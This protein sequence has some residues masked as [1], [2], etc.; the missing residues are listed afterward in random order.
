MTIDIQFRREQAWLLWLPL[1]LVIC[2][3]PGMIVSLDPRANYALAAARGI[4]LIITLL[5]MHGIGFRAFGNRGTRYAKEF[6]SQYRGAILAIFIPSLLASFP[7][8]SLGALVVS[9][10]VFYVIGCATLGATAFGIEFEHRTIGALLAQ[11]VSRWVLLGEKLLPLAT[12]LALSYL[13][14]VLSALIHVLP[15]SVGNVT[16]FSHVDFG[17]NILLLTIPPVFAFCTGPALT[18]LTRRTLAAAVFTIALPPIIVIGLFLSCS[19]LYKF[20]HSVEHGQSFSDVILPDRIPGLFPLF[21][22]LL[23]L[24]L[25]AGLI[26]AVVMFYRL[27]WKESVAQAPS[28]GVHPLAIPLDKLF[29]AA[30]GQLRISG[31]SFKTRIC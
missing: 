5:L 15:Q 11:P 25:F 7:D 29:A 20:V 14:F 4:V 31:G 12:L 26:G 21:A 1:I 30:L 27:G 22:V 3:L 23:P 8:P 17:E 24:Y 2:L 28:S 6:R 10:G 13:L 16:M 9:I 19:A 18:L